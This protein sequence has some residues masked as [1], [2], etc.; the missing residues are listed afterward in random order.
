MYNFI[1]NVTIN[2]VVIAEGGLLHMLNIVLY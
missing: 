1:R 2:L